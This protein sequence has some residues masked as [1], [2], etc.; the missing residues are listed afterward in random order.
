MSFFELYD[1]SVIA[2]RDLERELRK[3]PGTVVVIA[4]CCGSGGLIGRASTLEDFNRGIVQVFSG[5]RGRAVLR[6][7]QVQGHRQRLAGSGQ[8]PHQL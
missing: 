6:R 7:R 4:D 1:G 3:V 5:N 8:L 2:A